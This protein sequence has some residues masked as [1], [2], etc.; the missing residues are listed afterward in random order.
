MQGE[1]D[2]PH[3]SAAQSRIALAAARLDSAVFH[4]IFV[5]L[6]EVARGQFF[7]LDFADTRDG[8]GLNNQVVAV[9]RGWS[10]IGLGVELVPVAEP[11][12]YRVILTA[13]RI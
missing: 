8:V 11:G 9:C 3:C 12:S 7:Q 1:M 2:T 4:Q 5:K 13:A 6:L 10:D